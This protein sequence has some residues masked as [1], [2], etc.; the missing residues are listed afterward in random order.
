MAPLRTELEASAARLADAD[1]RLA[2]ANS[3]LAETDARLGE[4]DARLAETGAREADARA[5]VTGL[6]EELDQALGEAMRLDSLVR[7]QTDD[8][9]KLV[10]QIGELEEALAGESGSLEAAESELERLRT[11]AARREEAFTEIE[12]Q[13]ADLERQLAEITAELVDERMKYATSEEER[14][15]ADHTLTRERLA[16]ERL[17]TELFDLRGELNRVVARLADAEAAAEAAAPAEETFADYVLF[18]PGESG[19][20]LSEREGTTPEPGTL[21]EI[22]GTPFRVL[23]VG[24]S[25]LPADRRR[26]VFVEAA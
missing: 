10:R 5:R 4:T 9:Q 1:A 24:R 18:V 3:R 7:A 6:E 19:Y 23:K 15:A 13:R 21:T 20:L 17:D 14:A 12:H 16:R 25:P 8:A 2:E 22:E 26:C 11:D